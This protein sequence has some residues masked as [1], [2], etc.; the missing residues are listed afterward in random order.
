MSKLKI[1][2]EDNQVQVFTEPE[3]IARQLE[4]INIQFQRWNPKYPVSKTATQEEILLAYDEQVKQI[5]SQYGFQSVDVINMNPNSPQETLNQIRQKF[6][7]EH[8]HSDD[9][10][11]YF[12]EGQG[13]F[14]IHHSN[15]VYQILCTAGDFIAVPAMTKHWFDMGAKPDFKCIRFFGEPNGWV[16]E[17]TG[18]DIARAY[19]LI[20]E[21]TNEYHQ[22]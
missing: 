5:Q 4:K 10:V 12:I 8:T 14:C 2:L 16:A 9:E 17:Y 11:R 6:L 3:S 1:F 19:P 20:E 15:T 7:S 21:F 22:A 18:D 13:L